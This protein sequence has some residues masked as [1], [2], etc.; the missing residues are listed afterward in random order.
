MDEERVFP[1]VSRRVLLGGVVGTAAVTLVGAGVVRA[2]SATPSAAASTTRL[3]NL[4]ERVAELIASVKAD[5][6]T[7]AGGIDVAM[8]DRLL[9]L[10]NDWQGLAASPSNTG[11]G[12]GGGEQT[13]A[14]RLLAAAG[15]AALAA[16]EEIVAQLSAFGLPSQET[17]VSTMLTTTYDAITAASA[18]ITSANDSNAADAL[19]SAQDLYTAAHDAYTAKRY[20]QAA[21]HDRSARRMLRSAQILI[22]VGVPNPKDIDGREQGNRSMRQRR[23]QRQDQS[24]ESAPDVEQGTPV[25]AP[26]PSF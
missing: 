20:A 2:Q 11:S 8:V 13:G 6:D 10:A 21:R 16:R 12:S 9:A 5:R 24:S 15:L 25:A 23:E 7:V 19:T 1:T 22:G 17:H 3:T 4:S 18:G 26:S 14:F